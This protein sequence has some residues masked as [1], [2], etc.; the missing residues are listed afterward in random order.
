MGKFSKRSLD[1]L[2]GVHPALAAVLTEAVKN[3][4]VDFTITE[5]VRT[6]TEQKGL[7]N[8]GRRGIKGEVK[9]TDKDGVTKKSNHQKKNDGYGHAIDLYPFVDGNLR[10][11]GP[12]V[13]GHL[14]KIALHIK[15]VAKAMDVKIIWGGDWKMVDMPHFELA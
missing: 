4:P 8:I 14:S 15:K 9:V 11:V 12:E 5:G 2:E 6:A 10:V 3:S 1:N 13:A 7:Y